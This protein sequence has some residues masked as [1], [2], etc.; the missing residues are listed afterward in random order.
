MGILF[1]VERVGE[2]NLIAILIYYL[3]FIIPASIF[4]LLI[5]ISTLDRKD[6]RTWRFRAIFFP[7]PTQIHENSALKQFLK[8]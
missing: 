3:N 7:P 8:N 5:R 4:W 1:T 6:F 2:V